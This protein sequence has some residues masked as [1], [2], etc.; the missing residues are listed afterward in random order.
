VVRVDCSETVICREVLDTAVLEA[1]D[2]VVLVG[3]VGG[4]G[5][6]VDVEEPKIT[7]TT[8]EGISVVVACSWPLVVVSA[9][10]R[11]SRSIGSGLLGMAAVG[12]VKAD[13]ALELLDCTGPD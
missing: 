7:T 13:E 3:I 8:V 10:D 1:C 5:V 2:E 9:L 11:S 12:W 6:I 4:I